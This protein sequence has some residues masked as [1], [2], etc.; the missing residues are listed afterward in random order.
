[1][2]QLVDN[3]FVNKISG[4]PDI[5]AQGTSRLLLM[6]N[7]LPYVDPGTILIQSEDMFTQIFYWLEVKT[8]REWGLTGQVFLNKYEVE[9]LLPKQ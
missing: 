3:K 8:Q 1:M 9:F 5:A 6:G 4:N 2:D 7:N